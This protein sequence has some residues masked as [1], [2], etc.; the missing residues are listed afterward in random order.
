[1][2]QK[3]ISQYLFDEVLSLPIH[4]HFPLNDMVPNVRYFK[5]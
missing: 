5:S 4:Q 3:Q 1:M 2:Y